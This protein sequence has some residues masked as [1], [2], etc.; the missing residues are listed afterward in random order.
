MDRR[1]PP[2]VTR[3]SFLATTGLAAVAGCLGAP[4]GGTLPDSLDTGGHP[5]PADDPSWDVPND[6]P[7]ANLEVETLVENLDVPWDI[8][9]TGTGDLFVTQRTGSLVR[10]DSG[11]VAE[12]TEL[13]EAI[14]AGS[15]APGSDENSWWVEGGE[16]GTL[17]VAAHPDYP[18]PS[19]VFVYYTTTADGGRTNRVVRYDVS[20]DDP[21]ATAE[22]VLE[23]I[24]ANKW[25]NG[26]RIAFGPD[27][28]LWVT[29]GDA[30]QPELAQDTA[31]LAGK[32]LRITPDGKPVPDNPDLD[33][34]PRVFTY[35][36]RNPQGLAWLPSDVPL[37]TEHGPAGR[38]EVSVLYPGGNYGWPNV[39]GY[40]VDD[41]F[42]AYAT[43][44]GVVPPVLNIG[45][46]ESWAPTGGT[47]YTG[48][49]V[50][51]WRNRLVMGGLFSQA[52]WV[53]TLTP[54][55]YDTPP[56][57]GVAYRYDA[58]WMDPNFAATAHRTLHDEL[59]RVRHVAQSPDG[60]CYAITSNRDGRA[61]GNFP[62]G[63]DDVLV[64]ITTT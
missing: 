46:V 9:F 13:P 36:H 30:G 41:E 38:D 62:R 37:A 16:G 55:G 8:A 25:H 14:D 31:S 4:G 44:D 10:L 52:I 26:G 22:P 34:D 33:G 53:V 6:S 24:P 60:D 42:G 23:G 56:T 57:D 5:T 54:P 49:D 29:T 12:V 63:K 48:G 3:R 21:P 61:R 39:R 50:P 40:P 11:D 59:G 58:P 15:V 45:D 19:F 2:A 64:R 28:A 51:A 1:P 17:G 27:D 32:I 7:R 18:D 47:F 35:G 43:H 20:A